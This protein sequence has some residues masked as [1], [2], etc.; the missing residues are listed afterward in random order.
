MKFKVDENLP[1]E[2]V[3]DLRK[4]GHEADSVWDEGLAGSPDPVII[5]RA[6]REGRI[7]LTLDK[8]M[9]DIRTYPPDRHPG[10]VLFR[11]AGAGRSNVLGFVRRHLP[12]LLGRKMSGHLFVVS[13]RGVR[14]RR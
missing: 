3:T 10:I 6:R 7:V 14:T 2:I 4:D 5:S 1:S 9:A 13:E 8:G 11:P 12:A